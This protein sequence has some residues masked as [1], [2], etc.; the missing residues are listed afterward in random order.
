MKHVKSVSR[1]ERVPAKA[2]A[3]DVYRY[4]F[5][6]IGLVGAVLGVVQQVS[7]LVSKSTG[8]QFLPM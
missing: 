8:D 1:F 5:N 7:D 4:S 6:S 3:D 2:D